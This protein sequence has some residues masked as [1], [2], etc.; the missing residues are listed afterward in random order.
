MGWLS[1]LIH[2][3]VDE[4]YSDKQIAA[5]IREEIK[6]RKPKKVIHED[7]PLSKFADTEEAN[8]YNNA[9]A[10]YDKAL[11]LEEGK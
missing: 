5:D 1:E 6:Q 9:L 2:K 3:G 7:Y 8:G 4:G 11:G 10:D